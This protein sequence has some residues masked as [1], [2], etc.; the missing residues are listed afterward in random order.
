[1]RKGIMNGGE[2]EEFRVE[3]EDISFSVY[4]YSTYAGDCT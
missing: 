4:E 2:Y 1:M 3:S